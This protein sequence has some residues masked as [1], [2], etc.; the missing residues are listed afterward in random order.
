MIIINNYK[1]ENTA[2][3]FHLT[4]VQEP[5]SPYLCRC[6]WMRIFGQQKIHRLSK[7]RQLFVPIPCYKESVRTGSSLYSRFE[8][9]HRLLQDM[10]EIIVN[11]ATNPHLR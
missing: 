3:C 10:R 2:P 11:L 6:K 9:N 8:H 7:L 1:C 4:E 5:Q